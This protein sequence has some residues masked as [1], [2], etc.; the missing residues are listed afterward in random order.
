[1]KAITAQPMTIWNLVKYT[2]NDALYDFD[3]YK[4]RI[5]SASPDIEIDVDMK[6]FHR[7]QLWGLKKL[8]KPNKKFKYTAILIKE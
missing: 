7:N 4:S 3:G 1:M 8:K 2:K 5:L 6:I